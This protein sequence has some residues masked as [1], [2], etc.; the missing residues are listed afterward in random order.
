MSVEQQPL[1][2]I[3]R[4]LERAQ[5]EQRSVRGWVRPTSDTPAVELT[6]APKATVQLSE[7]HLHARHILCG[8]GKEDPAVADRY[9]LLRTRVIQ[10]LKLKSM[11]TIGVTS[12]GPQDG[13]SLTSIN[14]AISIAREGGYKVILIDADLRKPS[15]A[16]DLGIPV[17]K[18]LIDHLSSDI[19]LSE[20][21]V[22]TDI[23]NLLVV[24]GRHAD[25]ALAVPELLSSEKMRQLIDQLHGRDRWIVVV[26]LPPVRL[27]DDVVALA[28]YLDG[29]L[30]VVREGK[31]GI[32]ELKE[33][34]EL[35]RNFPIL[36]TVLN[37]STA[38]KLR[39]EGYYYHA[40]SELK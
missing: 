38:R 6:I 8:R 2:H 23:A 34:V 5:S 12:P 19:D 21:L 36:G 24:P 25:T 32:D 27:G 9:R 4:A 3:S 39:F 35:L 16:D 29:L 30:V 28:P 20:I 15:V 37:H 22:A 18:G 7:A 10:A 1:D 13:K 17:L 40:P 14:L 26:D 11:N 33:S 31:T